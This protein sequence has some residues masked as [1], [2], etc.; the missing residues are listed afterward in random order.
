MASNRL[1]DLDSATLHPYTNLRKHEQAGPLVAVRGEGVR[2]FDDAGRSYI[3][4]M[5]GLWCASL[6]FSQARLGEAAKRQMN[7]LGFY[8]QFTHKAH[9]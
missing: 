5:A 3:D 7:E 4:A 6:G 1:R 9:D 8:H 2:I